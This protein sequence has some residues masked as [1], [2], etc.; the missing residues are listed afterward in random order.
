[1]G[2]RAG[3]HQEGAD[4]QQVINLDFPARLGGMAKN[5]LPV[6]GMAPQQFIR[7]F[8]DKAVAGS[9]SLVV[10][11]HYFINCCQAANGLMGEFRRPLRSGY[12][13]GGNIA[14]DIIIKC[15]DI[16]GKG[17]Q[18]QQMRRMQLDTRGTLAIY[19]AKF[20][21]DTVGDV[22]DNFGIM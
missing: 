16:A 22:N 17:V 20:A 1:M 8:I 15:S 13:E 6:P 19:G 10:A 11:Q 7:T 4:L 3:H 12:K 5:T 14:V 9:S 18:G 21:G 2:H